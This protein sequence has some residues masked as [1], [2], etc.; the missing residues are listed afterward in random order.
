MRFFGDE[1]IIWTAIFEIS[2][3]FSFIFIF[4]K[5][6]FQNLNLKSLPFCKISFRRNMLSETVENAE[7][8]NTQIESVEQQREINKKAEKAMRTRLNYA[9]R[10]ADPEFLKTRGV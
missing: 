5:I 7:D 8:K 4:I 10:S 3:K 2:N 1:Q 9:R 6:F